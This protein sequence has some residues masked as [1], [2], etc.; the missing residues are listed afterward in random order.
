MLAYI[1]KQ[2]LKGGKSNWLCGTEEP[3]IAD[4]LGVA[5]IV[6]AMLAGEKFEKFPRIKNW[7]Y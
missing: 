7:I 3:T 6:M 5:D 4:I 2:Y 1:D